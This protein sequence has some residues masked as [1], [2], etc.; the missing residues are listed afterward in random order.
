[1][2][3]RDAQKLIDKYAKLQS[4]IFK[5][6]IKQLKQTDLSEVTADNIMQWQLEQLSKVGPLTDEVIKQ[7]AKVNRQTPADVKALCTNLGIEAVDQVQSEIKQH[8]TNET[9]VTPN[10]P[11]SVEQY[12]KPMQR[13]LTHTANAS[14]LDRNTRNNAATRVFKD[15]VNQTTL[16][17][18]TGLKTHEQA[19]K[20]NVYRWSDKGIP[21]MLTDKSGRGWSLEGYARTVVTTNTRQVFNDLRKQTMDV[22]GVHLAKMSWHACARETCAPIQGEI[23][24]MV[25]TSSPD[26]DK[27]YDTIYNHGYGEPAGTMGINCGHV[28]TPWDPDV[29]IEHDDPAR[30]SPEQAIKQGKVQ[31]KQRSM[32]RAIRA[33]KKKLEIAKELDDDAGTARYQRV[34]ANQQ[35]SMRELVASHKFLSRDYT[36]E[37]ILNVDERAGKHYA[38]DLDSVKHDYDKFK[39]VVG[40]RLPNVTVDSYRKAKYNNDAEWKQIKL[41]FELQKNVESG[42][43]T[44]SIKHSKQ[45]RHEYGT[46]DYENYVQKNESNG[47]PK[48]SYFV[49]DDETIQDLLN[50][51]Y[52]NGKISRRNPGQYTSE[53]T[54]D[55]DKYAYAYSMEN[56][57]LRPTNR[58]KIHFSKKTTHVVPMFPKED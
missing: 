4:N 8:T 26:Y 19:I 15:I 42:E 20:D 50:D 6:L 10:V 39:A 23:V 41:K 18:S 58:F 29:N 56:G 14:L 47:K 45:V 33:T 55:T 57:E 21:T 2:Q 12:I 5:I 30:P 49:V 38:A 34:L 22:N 32:E 25:P 7:V 51:N 16:E 40:D 37:R 27:R 43:I 9:P 31:Q 36:R 24:N 48:P 1:M 28:F 46:V 3:S 13:A 52:L 53:I 17:V 11:K 44:T 54:I 35:K